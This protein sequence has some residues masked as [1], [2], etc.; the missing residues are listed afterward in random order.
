MKNTLFTV[1]ARDFYTA[2][3]FASKDKHIKSL[4]RVH[5]VPHHSGGCRVFGL[6]GFNLFAAY[7]PDCT[8]ERA[9]AITPTPDM[10]KACKA[11]NAG[12]LSLE[13]TDSGLA[14]FVSQAGKQSAQFFLDQSDLTPT[15]E[16]Q[17]WTIPDCGAFLLS[18][19]ASRGSVAQIGYATRSFKLL[20]GVSDN[21]VLSSGKSETDP[22]L[23]RF[24]DR[25]NCIAVVMPTELPRPDVEDL[26]GDGNWTDHF[27][28]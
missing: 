23:V 12:V 6:D 8:P 17:E 1:S 28:L 27:P 3:Q 9:Y 7:Q 5:V 2:A 13:M 16:I 4:S 10:I 20:H 24:A 15:G 18:V 25:K 26:D 21:A 14:M 22:V 19:L 11:K